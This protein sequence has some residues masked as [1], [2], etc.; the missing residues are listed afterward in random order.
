MLYR[1]AEPNKRY[2][3][4]KFGHRPELVEEA[5]RLFDDVVMKILTKGFQVT[6][7]PEKKICQEYDSKAL[8]TA[9]GLIREIN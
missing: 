8:C 9:E 6:K 7:A 2:A 1:T 5:G 4:A 3:V